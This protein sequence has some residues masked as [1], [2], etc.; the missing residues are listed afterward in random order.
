MTYRDGS[1]RVGCWACDHVI[2]CRGERLSEAD[3]HRLHCP[4]CGKLALHR[5]PALTFGAWPSEAG[6]PPCE[7]PSAPRP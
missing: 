7:L 5:F 6:R 1:L 3:V 4:A 2:G